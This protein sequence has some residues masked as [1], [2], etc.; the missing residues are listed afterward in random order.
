MDH[1]LDEY[2]RKRDASRTNEPLGEE[3]ARRGPTVRGAFVVH[4]HAATAMHW[5]LRLEIGGV[6]AS[7]AV[8]KGPSLDPDL[9]NLAMHTEDHPIEYLD[10][11][12]VI[13][14]GTYG[15]GPMIV[16]DHGSVRFLETSAEEGLVEGKL[17]FA[18]EGRKLRGRYG[19]VRVKPRAGGRSKPGPSRE[20]LLL[21]KKDEFADP[22][23]D[24]VK[25]L[26]RSVLSGLTVS[27]LGDAARI[28]REVEEAAAARGA[29]LLGGGLP[30]RVDPM[31]CALGPMPRG[32]KWIFEL[33]MDGV[34]IVARKEERAVK[35]TYR[36]QRDA[37]GAYPEVV[38]AVQALSP[39]RLIL[40]GEVVAFDERGRPS[41]HRLASRIQGGGRLDVRGAMVSTPVVYTVFDLL[42]IGERDLRPLP[43]LDR[44]ALLEQLIPGPG[45]LRVLDHVARDGA[46]LFSFC[47]ENGLEGV[48]AKKASSPYR[49]GPQRSG[50][51]VK[52]KCE[53][54]ADFVVVGWT[55]SDNRQLRALDLASWASEELIVCGAV[56]SG[57]DEAAMKALLRRFAGAEV[58]RPSAEGTYASAPHGRTHLRPEVVVSVRFLEWSP[59]GNLRFPVFMGLRAGVD[60]RACTARPEGGEPAEDGDEG[61]PQVEPVGPLRADED[62]VSESPPSASSPAPEVKVTNRTKVFWPVEQL[63]KG[64]LIDYYVAVAPWLLPYLADR[65]VMLVRYP[66]GIDGKS[67]YQWNVPHGMPAWVKSV[68]L[69]RHAR[70]AEGDEAHGKNVFL[71]DRVE[72]LAYVA[73]LACIPVHVL[74][75]RVSSPEEADWLTIDFDVGRSSLRAAIPL[76][77]LLRAVC[78]EIGLPSFPKT[79]GQTGLHVFVALGPGTSPSAART[80]AD[81]LGRILVEAHPDAATME[82]VV[83]KRGARVYVDTGQTGPSRTIVAPLSVRA[84]AGAR[85]STTLTWDEVVP[86]L[87]PSVFT[88]RTVPDRLAKMGDPMTALLR[89]GPDMASV[90][91]RLARVVGRRQRA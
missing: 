35:L 33:K 41:F 71:L 7:F 12:A 46:P 85:V 49:E 37:T 29:P 87:D 34:R 28:A 81:L 68:S 22:S 66:D 51:W 45:V 9:R 74:A 61:T 11:E 88:I 16:W 1:K 43:L 54:T 23:R 10:F 31:L 91:E 65:P 47:R 84:T 44:K 82:R 78:D 58:P 13:P 20:W 57:F 52:T 5:D 39:R 77:H 90:M 64:D 32:P 55:R 53:R 73:N 42:A 83:A 76:A 15:A 69:G 86:D 24:V 25:E 70:A 18:L 19:L 38:R 26:P 72:S 59:D 14:E 56:G 67:F 80:L 75:S 89:A 4:Q 50:D 27:E 6:L 36:S 48:V 63:T 40:D 17:H 30:A 79:S 2:R 21:K 60:V 3:P 62:V 8:P